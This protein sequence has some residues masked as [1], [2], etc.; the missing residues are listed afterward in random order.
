MEDDFLSEAVILSGPAP[1]THSRRD[2]RAGGPVGLAGPGWAWLAL[3]LVPCTTSRHRR[4]RQLRTFKT[5]ITTTTATAPRQTL[6]NQ[7]CPFGQNSSLEF[8]EFPVCF[9]DSF[10]YSWQ[11]ESVPLDEG[12]IRW[13]VVPKKISKEASEHYWPVIIRGP[14]QYFKTR[15]A[16][17]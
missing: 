9:R 17:L 1:P 16:N 3:H 11:K 15:S 4:H 6:T 12:R 10:R 7:D 14:V 13:K 5:T 8:R 2:F